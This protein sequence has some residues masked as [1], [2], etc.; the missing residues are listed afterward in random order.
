MGSILVT[1][2]AGFVG[3]HL[4]ERLLALGHSVTCLDNLSTG[5][6]RNVTHLM[7][8]LEF[9]FVKSDACAPIEWTEPLDLI[10]HLASPAS[11]VAYFRIP[12]ETAM[13]NARGTYNV[14]EVARIHDSR[15]LIASTSEVYGDPEVHPQTEDYWGNVNPVGL[16]SAYDEGKRFAE[17]LGK[18]YCGQYGLDVR[19]TR[20]FNTYGPRSD[21][22]DGRMIPN[23]VRQALSGEPLTIFG[24][25]D[26]TR[27]L[28]Y[29]DDLVEGLIAAMLR[30]EAKGEVINLGC[31]DERTVRE[32]AQLIKEMTS[33]PSELV[34]GPA[35]EEEPMRRRPDITKAKA[36]L[37]WEPQTPLRRGLEPTIAWFR[38]LLP[39]SGRSGNG[40][41]R[42]QGAVR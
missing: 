37:G 18:A 4:C 25:G 22:D 13:V 41:D 14:L 29:V 3:S 16:R 30:P 7:D 23:F 8:R 28:C 1:G 17:A 36:L 35:R 40:A 15:V 5:S 39:V 21:P 27:S 12:I 2:G 10:F 19:I 20:I 26:Q 9:T 24:S 32:Y 11:P 42:I 38:K 33:S 6:L 34:T 31:P